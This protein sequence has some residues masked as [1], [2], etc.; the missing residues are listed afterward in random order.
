ML[1]RDAQ[2][3]ERDAEWDPWLSGSIIFFFCANCLAWS[4]S[5]RDRNVHTRT[6]K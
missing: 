3:L 6:T 1:A 5:V 4:H 2:S